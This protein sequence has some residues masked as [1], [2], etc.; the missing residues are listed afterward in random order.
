MRPHPFA[1]LAVPAIVCVMGG[2]EQKLNDDNYAL[3]KPGMTQDQ[4]ESALR[5]GSGTDE[6]PSGVSMSGSGLSGSRSTTSVYVYK[7]RDRSVTV[8]YQDGKVRDVNKTGF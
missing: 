1:L 8:T 3:I 2:C 6:T 4:V 5:C 7:C